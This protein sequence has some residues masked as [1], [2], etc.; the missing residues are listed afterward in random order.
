MFADVIIIF[1]LNFIVNFFFALSPI[2]N[3]IRPLNLKY[4]QQLKLPCSS[5]LPNEKIEWFG[6]LYVLYLASVI[7]CDLN[8]LNQNWAFNCLI[9]YSDQSQD[10]STENFILDSMIHWIIF[11][12]PF[13]SCLFSV[14]RSIVNLQEAKV[15]VAFVCH[16]MI[17][18]IQIASMAP[19]I[20]PA[21][22]IVV[23]SVAALV[24]ML[25][26]KH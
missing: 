12:L 24:A 14:C 26:Q 9:W 21:I 25:H 20:R 15:D 18:M 10:K 19:N 1:F 16:P 13:F 5:H 2:P 22:Q 6:V 3:L 7:R 11:F 17:Q 8:C 23:V 4:N